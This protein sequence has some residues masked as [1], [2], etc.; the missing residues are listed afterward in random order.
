MWIAIADL[1]EVRTPAIVLRFGVSWLEF[2]VWD[3][4]WLEFEVWGLVFRG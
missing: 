3:S 1:M 4:G 2:E